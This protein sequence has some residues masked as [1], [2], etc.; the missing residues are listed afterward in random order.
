MKERGAGAPPGAAE[1]AQ[2]VRLADTQCA[3]STLPR[4]SETRR[5][6]LV[7]RLDAAAEVA[8]EEFD[9]R[10]VLARAR[11]DN[12]GEGHRRRDKGRKARL[13][14]AQLLRQDALDAA[15]WGGV[16]GEAAL[17]GTDESKSERGGNLFSST[18]LPAPLCISPT[19]R[20]PRSPLNL[21]RTCARARRDRGGDGARGRRRGLLP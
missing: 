4:H 1:S 17:R 9:R 3:R 13:H 19:P 2:F 20:I 15:R 14:E 21:G 6:L 16:G 11:D 8:R 10:V 5:S 12:V 7:A 18:L